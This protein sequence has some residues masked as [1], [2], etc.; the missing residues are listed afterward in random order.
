M[1]ILAFI[2]LIRFGVGLFRDELL[3]SPSS[4]DSIRSLIHI[5]GAGIR[6]HRITANQNIVDYLAFV[7]RRTE[8]ALVG[9]RTF[10]SHHENGERFVLPSFHGTV[11]WF[12]LSDDVR[13]VL[14]GLPVEAPQ[15]YGAEKT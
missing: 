7:L 11:R 9:I 4:F 5:E 10:R 2:G 3:I 14:S 12:G 8:M 6:F 15:L 13:E 1:R